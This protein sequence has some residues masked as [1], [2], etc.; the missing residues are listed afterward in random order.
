MSKR[1]VI[2]IDANDWLITFLKT[3]NNDHPV[4]YRLTNMRNYKTMEV[5]AHK[6]MDEIVNNKRNIRNIRCS[7]NKVIVVTEDG[8][9]GTD[10]IIVVDEFDTDVQNI[11]EWALSHGDLG[12]QIL[13]M[14]DNSLN[15]VAPSNIQ[16]DSTKELAWKCSEGH[17]I[18]MD[19]ATL[20]GLG[21][22]CPICKAKASNKVLSLKAWANLTNNEDLLEQYRSCELNTSASSNLAYDSKKKVYWRKDG[23]DVLMSV[24]DVTLKN[25]RPFVEEKSINL[26]R[27]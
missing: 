7:S 4:Y 6:L 23:G 14:Y 1:E 9:D 21:C 16:I 27:G 3:V 15:L 18:F 17:N 20:V 10:E 2:N 24:S 12:V 25:K 13:S 19:F 5:A 8:Y 11:Y 22:E 26:S